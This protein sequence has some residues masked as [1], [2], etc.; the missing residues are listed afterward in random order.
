MAFLSQMSLST[1][2][3]TRPFPK[4]ARNTSIGPSGLPLFKDIESMHPKELYK[5]VMDNEYNKDRL[6]IIA[7][8]L[9]GE[10]TRLRDQVRMEKS[11]RKVDISRGHATAMKWQTEVA[12]QKIK[13]LSQEVK[14]GNFETQ[15]SMLKMA[16]QALIEEFTSFEKDIKEIVE[17]K[18]EDFKKRRGDMPDNKKGE[19]LL[20]DLEKYY[21]YDEVGNDEEDGHNDEDKGNEEGTGEGGDRNEREK[22]REKDIKGGDILKKIPNIE[23]DPILTNMERLAQKLEE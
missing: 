9:T 18:E 22:R 11:S 4:L 14:I 8:M 23:K 5:L 20:E 15:I 6:Y 3:R 10:I 12:H 13:I 19:A 21:I 17:R 7:M 1:A 2:Q 16:N